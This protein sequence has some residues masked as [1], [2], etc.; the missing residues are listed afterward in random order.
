M[1]FSCSEQ[2]R[3]TLYCEGNMNSHRYDDDVSTYYTR[4]TFFKIRKMNTPK[5]LLFS[6]ERSA[7]PEIT[8]KTSFFWLASLATAGVLS[9]F[10]CWKLAPS[11]HKL[12]FGQKIPR[13]Q[14]SKFDFFRLCILTPTINPISGVFR[15]GSI[16]L[17]PLWDQEIGAEWLIFNRFAS[18]CCWSVRRSPDLTAIVITKSSPRGVNSPMKK[19][20]ITA[21][22]HI[23]W[24]ILAQVFQYLRNCHALIMNVLVAALSVMGPR[25]SFVAH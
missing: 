10:V 19:Y 6:K 17:F 18:Q 23:L 14:A 4:R 16:I 11:R 25:G 24:W 3:N 1:L 7:Q 12:V 15:S 9:I 8:V 2:C 13:N 5:D 21:R 20:L 22:S